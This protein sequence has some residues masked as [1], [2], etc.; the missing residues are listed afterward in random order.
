MWSHTSCDLLGSGF[1]GNSFWTLS[2]CFHLD[3]WFPTT[4]KYRHHWNLTLPP[5]WGFSSP[6]CSGDLLFCAPHLLSS[7]FPPWGSLPSVASWESTH[8]KWIFYAY[9]SIKMWLLSSGLMMVFDRFLSLVI[10][11]A[12][13]CFKK[14]D[15][16]GN[17]YI[18][19]SAR[20]SVTL[21]SLNP[22]YSVIQT[23]EA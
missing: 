5:P 18:V 6:S 11:I 2:S 17:G 21:H 8:G 19:G 3:W 1:L 12:K 22:L 20:L 15:K 4:P 14:N 9:E 13:W 16:V 7:L 23:L 10:L